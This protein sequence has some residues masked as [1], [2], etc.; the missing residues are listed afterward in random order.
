MIV[1]GGS[2]ASSELNSGGRYDPATNTWTA[3]STADVPSARYGHKSVWTGTEMIVWGG[4]K[5]W[6]G[7]PMNTGGRYRPATNTWTATSTG[8]GVPSARN[9]HTS[10]WTGREMIVWGG[11]GDAP[12]LNS[13][14]R[15]D[16][17]TDS[18]TPTSREGVPPVRTGHSALWTGH[19]MIVWGGTG[20]WDGYPYYLSGG[21]RYDP[22]ADRWLPVQNKHTSP[23]ALVP[24]GRTGHTA[25]WT[26]SE[27][28]V[29]GGLLGAPSWEPTASGWSYCAPPGP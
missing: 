10:V 25:V 17:L 20:H 4:G 16:P 21:A 7:G 9:G 22:L 13:G 2:S 6:P 14:A 18:W 26:G 28:I 27:M 23:D 3:T 19:E 24:D 29:W 8:T 5:S 1:W 15:Y 11:A 12:S